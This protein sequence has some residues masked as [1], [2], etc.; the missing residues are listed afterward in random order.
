MSDTRIC[1]DDKPCPLVADRGSARFGIGL[2][3]KLGSSI[4]WTFQ[5]SAIDPHEAY[6]G[7]SSEFGERLACYKAL[8]DEVIN[9]DDVKSIGAHV[10][11][12]KVYGPTRFQEQIRE[13]TGRSGEL[14]PMGR[15]RR[16][17]LTE[18]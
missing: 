13:L 2:D 1:A 3:A 11:Q 12:G 15:P 7:L 5:F 17:R 14:R 18:K 8:L 16:S 10:N 4:R 9:E 6:D